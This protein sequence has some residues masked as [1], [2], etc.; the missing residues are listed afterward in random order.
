M[1]CVQV[2]KE[3]Q[4]VWKEL[5]M[6][7]KQ[8]KFQTKIVNFL[9]TIKDDEIMS[10]SVRKE[11]NKRAKDYFEAVEINGEYMEEQ[12]LMILAQFDCKIK[13]KVHEL[14]EIHGSENKISCEQFQRI[15]RR[16]EIFEK[17]SRKRDFCG[18]MFKYFASNKS[19]LLYVQRSD[20]EKK[21]EINESEFN[22]MDI[23]GD[24][25]IRLLDFSI[26]C[27][28]V[29]VCLCDTAYIY[30]CVLFFQKIKKASTNL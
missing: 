30:T 16:N 2:D 9:E 5:A 11:C 7:Y 21:I 25:K 14:L 24:G 27:V 28:C 12:H 4:K 22:D 10:Q 1:V 19:K 18:K 20:F 26:C 3:K 29:C 6:I 15:V 23:Y 13:E 17:M 8:T